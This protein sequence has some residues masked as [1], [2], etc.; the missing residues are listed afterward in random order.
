MSSSMAGLGRLRRARFGLLLCVLMAG[1]LGLAS[2][3]T[4]VLVSSGEPLTKAD[5]EPGQWHRV[6]TFDG[7]EVTDRV[8]SV[9]DYSVEF[10]EYAVWLSDIE[11]VER[12]ELPDYRLLGMVL[13]LSAYAAVVLWMR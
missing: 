6:K 11:T 13:S 1:T 7:Q 5:F 8:V 3:G 10:R 2:C 12:I 4:Y 9:N